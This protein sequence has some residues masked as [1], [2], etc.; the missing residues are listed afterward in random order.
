MPSS[1]HS[2]VVPTPAG[3]L[4]SGHTLLF[5]DTLPGPG[6]CWLELH[7]LSEMLFSFL[8]SFFFLPPLQEA[9]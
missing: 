7:S 3:M 2:T 9:H 8:I 4:P 6:R 1:S 5:L